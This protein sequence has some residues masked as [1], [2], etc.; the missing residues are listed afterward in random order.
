[1]KAG[2]VWKARLAV[3]G[4]GMTVGSGMMV[5]CCGLTAVRNGMLTAGSVVMTI[6]NGDDGD[7]YRVC[8]LRAST[9]TFFL[10]SRGC[11]L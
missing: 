7:R 10:C 1:M 8:T 6:A 11:L 2:K 5:S 4:G 3:A 9:G